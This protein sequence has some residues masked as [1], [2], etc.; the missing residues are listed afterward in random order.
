ML[1]HVLFEA[2]VWEALAELDQELRHEGSAQSWWQRDSECAT[3]RTADV[4]DLFVQ[5]AQLSHQGSP[6]ACQHLPGFGE[7]KAA[8]GAFY[9]GLADAL[10]ESSEPPGDG[11]TGYV[12]RASSGRDATASCQMDEGREA[13]EFIHAKECSDFATKL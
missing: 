12:E 7:S 10:F 2:N 9:Q 1:S 11:G 4:R 8:S 5:G 13:W 6:S 3:G